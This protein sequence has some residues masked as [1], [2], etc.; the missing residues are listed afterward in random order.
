MATQRK[1]AKV[2]YAKTALGLGTER[3]EIRSRTSN[4]AVRFEKMVLSRRNQLT[5]GNSGKYGEKFE[6]D[7]I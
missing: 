5:G 2:T 6:R 1:S 7:A 3:K 4:Q